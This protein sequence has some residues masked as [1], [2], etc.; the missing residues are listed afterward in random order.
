MEMHIIVI[1]F[2]IIYLQVKDINARLEKIT[3]QVRSSEGLTGSFAVADMKPVNINSKK[4][5]PKAKSS[6]REVSL[7][8]GQFSVYV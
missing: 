7:F 8:G 4:N 3:P 1:F 5:S 6:N 2:H